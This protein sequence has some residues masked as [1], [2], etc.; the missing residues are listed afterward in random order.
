MSCAAR[1]PDGLSG[2]LSGQFLRLLPWRIQPEGPWQGVRKQSV[3][4]RS[5]GAGYPWPVQQGRMG[6]AVSVRQGRHRES[7]QPVSVLL[8]KP[9]KTIV[10]LSY[11]QL[12]LCQGCTLQNSTPYVRQLDRPVK[13]YPEVSV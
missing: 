3:W 6:G 2:L 13:A 12:A 10:L 1:L 11:V 8:T 7:F 5:S 4:A 9:R